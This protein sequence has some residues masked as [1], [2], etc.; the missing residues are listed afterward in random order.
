MLARL[1]MVGKFA[2]QPWRAFLALQYWSNV[3]HYAH[4]LHDRFFPKAKLVVIGHTHRAGVWHLP[5][6]TL[7]NTG[8]YQ[9]LSKPIAAIL[10][11]GLARMFDIEAGEGD[12]R[13]GKEVHHMR[14]E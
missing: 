5:A 2:I 8:S 6:F 3:V 7:V 1:L 13:L 4:D 11:P 12:F 9:P 14:W 10:E